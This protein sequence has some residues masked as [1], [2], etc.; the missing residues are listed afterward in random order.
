MKPINEGILESDDNILTAQAVRDA[1]AKVYEVLGL[2]REILAMKFADQSYSMIREEK[3]RRRRDMLE[4]LEF[5]VYGW[6][7]ESGHSNEEVGDVKRVRDLVRL[8]A[9]QIY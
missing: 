7:V 6:G 8:L 5:I 1:K 2:H 3:I 9:N 4:Q